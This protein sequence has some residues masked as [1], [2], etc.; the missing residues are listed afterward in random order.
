MRL[1]SKAREENIQEKVNAPQNEPPED[2]RISNLEGE[3]DDAIA[4]AARAEL[5]ATT[6]EEELTSLRQLTKY[7]Y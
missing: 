7:D 3:R 6:A 1:R 4:R 2:A 5:R